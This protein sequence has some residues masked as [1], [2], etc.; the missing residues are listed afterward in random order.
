MKLKSGMYIRSKNGIAKIINTGFSNE[1]VDDALVVDKELEFGF[2]GSND[3]FLC[4]KK[5]VIKASNNIINIIEVGDIVLFRLNG[6]LYKCEV[7]EVPSFDKYLKVVSI[8]I[9]GQRKI[10]KLKELNILKILT[11]ESFENNCYK[12]GDE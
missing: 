3:E 2:V 11:H 5:N 10:F 12:I 4:D 6:D 1:Y 9:C 7:E 8:N